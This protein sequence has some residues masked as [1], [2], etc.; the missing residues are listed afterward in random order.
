MH[1][2]RN[3]FVESE[4]V[5]ATAVHNCKALAFQRSAGMLYG[6]SFVWLFILA[7][8]SDGLTVMSHAVPGAL[9]GDLH[10]LGI[11]VD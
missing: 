8:D 6:S 3:R 5:C 4:L 10:S 1:H 9:F 7:Y 11:G 2:E